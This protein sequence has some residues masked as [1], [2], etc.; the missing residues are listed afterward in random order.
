MYSY[1]ITAQEMSDFI[2]DMWEMG[3]ADYIPTDEEMEEMARWY[4]EA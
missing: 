1:E 3:G 4:G 2:A